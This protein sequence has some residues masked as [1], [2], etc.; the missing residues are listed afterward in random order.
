LSSSNQ[1]F[2]RFQSDS[3]LF[4]DPKLFESF[5][6]FPH[7]PLPNFQGVSSSLGHPL[8]D[9]TSPIHTLDFASFGAG[10]LTS[11]FGQAQLSSPTAGE[12][13]GLQNLNHFSHPSYPSYSSNPS[14]PHRSSSDIF[15]TQ[16]L[17]PAP[18]P[19][20]SRSSFARQSAPSVRHDNLSL[21]ERPTAPSK[22]GSIQHDE[23]EAIDDPNFRRRAIPGVNFGSDADF[24]G[25]KYSAPGANLKDLQSR[26]AIIQAN[27]ETFQ[28]KWEGDP[29]LDGAGIKTK[30]RL[31]GSHTADS[32][33]GYA[34]SHDMDDEEDEKP[35]KKAKKMRQYDDEDSSDG[36]SPT[37]PAKKSKTKSKSRTLSDGFVGTN[38]RCKSGPIDPKGARQN[39]TEE[40][41]K[42]NHIRSEQKRRNQIKEGFADLTAM[43]PDSSA[44]ASKCAILSQAVD[45]LSGL[46]EGNEQLRAQLESM[47]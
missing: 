47:Q 25:Q 27:L 1:F 26:E 19:P 5:D 46:I 2:E 32:R 22:H 44:G 17:F 3:G 13:A 33:R 29:E 35:A 15:G 40:E 8:I 6:P 11:R 4:D 18:K 43:M 7:E 31:S 10:D 36:A 23:P 30:R 14:K 38:G 20:K 21:N 34:I 41:K 42:M 39:L 12:N 9:S 28:K 37:R 45:W 24:S 16:S